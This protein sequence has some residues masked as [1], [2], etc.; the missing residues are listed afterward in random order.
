MQG[1]QAI[2]RNATRIM[3]AKIQPVALVSFC[4][5]TRPAARAASAGQRRA[6]PPVFGR[7]LEAARA[8]ARIGTHRLSRTKAVGRTRLP[9]G[10]RAGARSLAF[11]VAG[12]PHG[13]GQAAAVNSRDFFYP[14]TFAPSQTQPGRFS[15]RLSNR[16]QLV[17]FRPNQLSADNRRHGFAFQ[18]PAEERAVLRSAR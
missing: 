8:A 12:L 13:Q 6:R 7:R 5:L 11:S 16:S 3:A 4:S 10:W 17:L 18:L 1:N 14:P 9:H 2:F 15:D